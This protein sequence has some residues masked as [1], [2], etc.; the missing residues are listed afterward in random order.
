MRMSAV[1]SCLGCLFPLLKDD[2]VRLCGANGGWFKHSDIKPMTPHIWEKEVGDE[3]TIMYE[4]CE[5]TI[6][7]LTPDDNGN[8]FLGTA[9]KRAHIIAEA[10]GIPIIPKDEYK[11]I[12][13]ENDGKWPWGKDE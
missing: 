8:L 4:T 7:L 2:C 13:R 3:M 10:L 5:D 12:L 6:E 11:R 9:R 1:A